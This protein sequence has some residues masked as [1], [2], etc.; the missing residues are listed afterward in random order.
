MRRQNIIVRGPTLVVRAAPRAPF[1]LD[2]RQQKGDF[3]MLYKKQIALLTLMV[4]SS[5]VATP[6]FAWATLADSQEPGSVLVFPLFETGTVM[7]T[8][9]GI[10][11]ITQIEISVV[12]PTGSSCMDGQDVDIHAHWVCS[13]N[14]VCSEKDFTVNTTVNG[15]IVINPQGGCQPNPGPNDPINHEACGS[16][17]TPPVGCKQGYLIA[18]VVN[19][20]GKPIKFDGLLGD[21]VLR[22]SSGAVTAYNAIPIQASASLMTSALVPTGPGGAL[23]FNGSSYT[24]VTGEITGGVRF[25]ATTATS[26]V[27]TSLILLT[28]DTLSNRPNYPIF[29]DLNFFNEVEQENS[30]STNFFCWASQDIGVDNTFGTKGLV[31]STAAV[32]VP[33]VG[34]ADTAGPATLLGLVLT[35]EVDPVTGTELRH[36]A[37][38]LLNDSKPVATSFVP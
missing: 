3:S 6:S 18:W 19:E 33:F 4:L 14:V 26:A 35:R 37:Y 36:Y 38:P 13:N 1:S 20:F 30:T 22:E 25:D 24:E 17:P 34:V 15:T 27:S 31:Q 23:L 8:D 12:C 11:P 5:W 9:Q 28:L 16:V 21:A 32:K 7:T 10:L 29:V 2:I